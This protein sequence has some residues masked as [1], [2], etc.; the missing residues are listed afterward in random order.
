MNIKI[1]GYFV[2]ME[3]SLKAS[4]KL[5]TFAGLFQHIKLFGEKI[6]VMFGP[7]KMYVQGMD[8]SHISIF[9][10]HLPNT[11]FDQYTTSDTGVTIGI[12]GHFLFK[13]L[14]TRERSHDM[15]LYL[16]SDDCDQLLIDFTSSE[17][18]VYDKHFQIPLM[19]V[20]SE[21]MHIPEMDYQAEFSL[22][23]TTFSVLVE[24]MRMFADDLNLFC[25]EEMIQMGSS[26]EHTGK[27]TVDIP[28]DDLNTFS[29]NE[30]QEIKASFSLAQMHNICL[31]NKI[32]KDV[33]ISL[34]DQFPI[35]LV[36][37][38]GQENAKLVFY[39]APKVDDH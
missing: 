10:I 24:Q 5:D 22:A 37:S 18:N 6:N 13:V 23:S 3:I 4:P 28:I 12:N 36:Y 39:L 8:N 2:T 1:M 33:E 25:S 11:W 27:M 17:T 21:T 30:G 32:T 38:L 19:E 34:M 14:S 20:D 35:R 7:D 31:Y 29:I 15:R 9:E 26:S 16:D